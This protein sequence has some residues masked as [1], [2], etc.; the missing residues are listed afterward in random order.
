MQLDIQNL[1]GL[2]DYGLLLGRKEALAIDRTRKEIG[3]VLYKLERYLPSCIYQNFLAVKQL[4]KFLKTVNE[5]DEAAQMKV[6]K[7]TRI[8]EDA[9]HKRKHTLRPDVRIDSLNELALRR[10]FKFEPYLLEITEAF[11]D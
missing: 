10:R 6:R 5:S 1:T 7:I 4:F 3:M 9:Y 2:I 11:K 8:V